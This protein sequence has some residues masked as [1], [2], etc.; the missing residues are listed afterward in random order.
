MA[1]MYME[2]E[3]ISSKFWENVLGGNVSRTFYM[4]LYFKYKQFLIAFPS[5]LWA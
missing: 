5:L 2:Q 1:V 3:I 4:D